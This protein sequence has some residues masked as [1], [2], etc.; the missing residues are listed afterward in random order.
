MPNAPS[1]WRGLDQEDAQPLRRDEPR[2]WEREANGINEDTVIE[3]KG[4]PPERGEFIPHAERGLGI[5]FLGRLQNEERP[6][7]AGLGAA[8]LR[9]DGPV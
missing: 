9:S 8:I 7:R 3:Q 5:D 6:V 1:S 4:R 2:R